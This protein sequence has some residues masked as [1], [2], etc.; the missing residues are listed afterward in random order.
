MSTIYYCIPCLTRFKC[1]KNLS[2]KD[3]QQRE[4][5]YSNTGKVPQCDKCL[6][7]HWRCKDK[8]CTQCCKLNE[9]NEI[10][11]SAC[12]ESNI[13]CQRVLPKTKEEFAI[14]EKLG[15]IYVSDKR[16]LA[17]WKASEL[18]SVENGPWEFGIYRY[19]GTSSEL[20]KSDD[21]L[22][23]KR[24]E[25]IERINHIIENNLTID[26]IL[27][28]KKDLLSRSW[29][30]SLKD[31]EYL[32]KKEKEI[33]ETNIKRFWRP[34]CIYLFGFGGSGKSGLIQELFGDCL[35]SKPQKQKSGSNWFNGY[36]KHEFVLFDEW[37]PPQEAFNF[38]N[39]NVI[40]NTTLHRDFVIQF[41]GNW[42]NK[43]TQIHFLK[44]SE[45]DFRNMGFDIGLRRSDLS[46]DEIIEKIKKSGF[47]DGEILFKD[48]KVYW[49]QNFPQYKKNYL[50]DYPNVKELYKYKQ[51]LENPPIELDNLDYD[52][53]LSEYN[54]DDS[55]HTKERKLKNKANGKR[56]ADQLEKTVVKKSKL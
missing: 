24:L 26:D 6:K 20:N 9:C 40:D 46:D 25:D 55:N 51:E 1:K 23:E 34:C 15:L 3:K 18:T 12:K 19:L 36:N 39:G 50:K 37:R 31:L 38:G 56:K 47:K 11:C 7:T 43:T 48:D 27:K 22:N 30:R 28:N 41:T 32:I 45:E 35:Y 4:E 16:I 42:N 14:L 21:T 10:E 54:S 52:S 13:K 17:R 33:R 8:K 53:Q 2:D 49:R 29:L 5:E 44:G